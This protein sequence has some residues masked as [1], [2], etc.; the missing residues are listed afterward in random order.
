MLPGDRLLCAFVEPQKAGTTFKA[1]ILHVTI[2][3]WF[4]LKDSSEVLAKGLYKALSTIEP[5]ESVANGQ[6]FIGPKKNRAATQLNQPSSF[7]KIEEKSRNYLH[8]KR[9]W[10]VDE[11]TK[12]K[13]KFHPHVTDQQGMR[14]N[15]GD[16]FWCDRLYIVE[17]KG[18]YK[19]IESEI[20]L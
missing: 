9:A 19:V 1:W 17:Q 13:R 6:V 3:P 16:T 14:L 10:L 11:T 20:I 7:E 5:F 15:S 8:K 18:D 2:V 4:R 12:K